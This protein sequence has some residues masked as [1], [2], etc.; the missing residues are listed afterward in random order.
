M[1]RARNVRAATATAFIGLAL[2]VG[3]AAPAT[4][5]ADSTGW[6]TYNGLFSLAG[7]AVY[8]DWSTD[9]KTATSTEAS[10]CPGSVRSG[11]KFDSSTY[12]YAPWRG[13]QSTMIAST[14]AIAHYSGYTS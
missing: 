5:A 13:Y 8:S 6:I 12:V 11:Q 10:S 3:A 9:H 14:A 2:A 1:P 7:C 4:S